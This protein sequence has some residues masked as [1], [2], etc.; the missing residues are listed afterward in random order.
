MSIFP[1]RPT[2]TCF[3]NKEEAL[4]KWRFR[5]RIRAEGWDDR[6][7]LQY[8]RQCGGVLLSALDLDV[9]ELAIC[10]RDVVI[11]RARLLRS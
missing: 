1:N 11:V 6:Q 5:Q 8:Y 3:T 4:S 9:Y 2:F 10:V 7:V